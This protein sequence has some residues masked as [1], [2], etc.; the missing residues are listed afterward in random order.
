MESLTRLSL[1]VRSSVPPEDLIAP[2]RQALHETDASVPFRTPLTMNEVIAETLTFERLESWLFGI[3]AGLALTLALVGIYGMVQHEVE[4]RTRDIGVRMAVGASRTRVVAEILRRV[5][6][7]MLGGIALGWALTL[8]LQKVLEAVVT[9][10]AA[11]DG[12][13][14]AALTLTLAVAGVGA[15]LVPARRAATIDPVQAL[16]NE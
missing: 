4:L 6:V 15:S 11:K 1:V 5:S 7:L 3:F 8:G 9:M 14:M 10:H 13:L 12:A 2:L 16:R